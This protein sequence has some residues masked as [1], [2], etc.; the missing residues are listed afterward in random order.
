M[1]IFPAPNDC[2]Q[3][4]CILYCGIPNGCIP[5]STPAYRLVA[6]HLA[7]S[8]MASQR[9]TRSPAHP[10]THSPAHPRIRSSAHLLTYSPAH[11]LT[12]SPA[13]LLTLVPTC[14]QAISTRD[15][16]LRA[17]N[18]ASASVAS[19]KEKLAKL[20]GSGKEDKAAAAE[21]DLQEAEETA[22]L[23]K[24]VGGGGGGGGWGRCLHESLPGACV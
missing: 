1:K 16:A 7:A 21:R 19:K 8:R 22:R 20:R 12:C 6:S 2:I 9:V 17:F 24:Q 11:L 3:H 18:S 10:L 15:G 13:H 23:A 4:D 5:R 14:L